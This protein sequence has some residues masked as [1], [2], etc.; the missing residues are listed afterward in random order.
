MAD[1]EGAPH[2]HEQRAVK[3]EGEPCGGGGRELSGLPLPGT[4]AS[5]SQGSATNTSSTSSSSIPSSRPRTN[6]T[7]PV[8]S[9]SLRV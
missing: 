9:P 1:A 2:S 6:G 5:S 4:G 7:V 3:G 8:R